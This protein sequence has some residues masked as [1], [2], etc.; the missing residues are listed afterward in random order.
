MYTWD[1]AMKQ[2]VEINDVKS[3]LRDLIKTHKTVVARD[4]EVGE[5]RWLVHCPAC[6]GNTQQVWM[7]G[8][9]EYKCAFWIRAEKL[10]LT[11]GL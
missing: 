10:G 6:D 5:P 4:P 2:F 9:P 7:T 8:D 1:D 3:L 11:D